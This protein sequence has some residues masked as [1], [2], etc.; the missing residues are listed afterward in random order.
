MAKDYFKYYKSE[1]IIPFILI[2][3]AILGFLSSILIHFAIDQVN[4][5]YYQF[6]S[7]TVLIG[8][9]IV[10]IDRFLWKFKPFKWLFLIDDISG[11]YKGEI[12]FNHYQDN[13]RDTREF[14][15]EIEQS[16]SEIKLTTYFKNSLESTSKSVSRSI[17]ITKDNFGNISIFMNYLNSG[18]PVLGIPEHHGT[19]ILHVN[20]TKLD[21][22]YYTDKEPQTKGLMKGK[23]I[24]KKLKKSF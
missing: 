21:G 19:N 8:L 15:L 6:P 5:S 12:I 10:L 16:G 14:F 11:R 13:A 4:L 20:N 24:S 7:T 9:L 2:S 3:G 1:Y 23:F 17:N 18:N 22:S